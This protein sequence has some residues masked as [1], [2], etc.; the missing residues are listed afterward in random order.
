MSIYILIKI[1]LWV[2]LGVC[3]VINADTFYRYILKYWWGKK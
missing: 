3:L 1:L 2:I